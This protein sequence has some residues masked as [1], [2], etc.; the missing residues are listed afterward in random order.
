MGLIDEFKEDP[1]RVLTGQTG[2]GLKLIKNNINL[3][4]V[5]YSFF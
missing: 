1:H 2:S 4:C 5:A 3:K